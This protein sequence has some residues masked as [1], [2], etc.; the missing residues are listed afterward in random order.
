MEDNV[1]RINT[2]QKTSVT[3][4]YSSN[5]EAYNRMKKTTT[6][7]ANSIAKM[8][9][10]TSYLAAARAIET[11]NSQI[12]GIMKDYTAYDFSQSAAAALKE[13][14]RSINYDISREIRESL[15]AVG[16]EF[17]AIDMTSEIRK[18]ME[19]LHLFLEVIEMLYLQP[20][21]EV[22]AG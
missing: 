1:I 3:S 6:S 20:L 11:V 9:T 10:D 14:S 16:R 15:N 17:S 7:L 4:V 19:S 13:M 18:S 21:Q 2:K 5:V 22:R 8:T 12:A